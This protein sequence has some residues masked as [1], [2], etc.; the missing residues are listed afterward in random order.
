MKKIW[1]WVPCF[2]LQK[3]PAGWCGV[4]EDAD[5]MHLLDTSPEQKATKVTK[6]ENRPPT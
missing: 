4:D 3:Q 6:A 1:K 5:D 2:R